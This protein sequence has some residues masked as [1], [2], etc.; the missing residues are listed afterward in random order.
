MFN[1]LI[2]QYLNNRLGANFDQIR[3]EITIAAGSTSSPIKSSRTVIDSFN[4]AAKASRLT[5]GDN[6]FITGIY[7]FTEP[8]KT[9]CTILP[10]NNTSKQIELS[11]FK[12]RLVEMKPIKLLETGISI[13]F[14]NAENQ[15]NDI[16]LILEGFWLTDENTAKFN[17]LASRF[18]T[19][20][21]DLDSQTLK[22]NQIA[23][24]ISAR[25]DITNQLLINPKAF[26]LQTLTQATPA[27]ILIPTQEEKVNVR[28]ACG[29]GK[30]APTEKSSCGTGG[31]GKEEDE[32][33]DE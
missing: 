6:F 30:I 5:G 9:Y 32:E 23:S 33:G 3:F 12:P 27:P 31:A 1:Q 15:S 7:S 13:D 26:T 4:G 29:L 20:L 16:T 8:G 24:G 17:D 22:G 19:I 2:G 28:R 18:Y 11:I 21:E 10:D 25:L 14:F